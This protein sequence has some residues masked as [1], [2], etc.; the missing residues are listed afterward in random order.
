MKDYLLKIADDSG[1]IEMELSSLDPT[2]SVGKFGFT[3]L[4]LIENNNNKIES[5]NSK[6]DEKIKVIM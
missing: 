5:G 1:E 4:A 6:I 3:H 2:N